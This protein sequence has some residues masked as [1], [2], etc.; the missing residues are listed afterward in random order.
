MKIEKL[1]SGSYRVRKMY[2]GKTYSVTFDDK[3]TQKAVL[4]ALSAE[5]DK[6]RTVR[7]GTTFA[8]A[9][10]EYADSK[11]NVLSPRT[12]KDY[13]EIPR[14]L[15]EWF[16][17]LPLSDISQ[18]EVN[19]VINELAVNRAP[20]TVRNYHGF[21]SAVLGTYRPDLALRTKLPQ[22]IK[23]EPYIPTQQD[24][25]VILKAAKG[26]KYEAAIWLACFGLRRSE[27]CALTPEDIEND[28]VHINKAIVLNDKKEWVLKANKT[29]DSSR[30]IVISME[31]AN[32]IREQG[33]VF[34]GNPG[35]ITQW[36][37]VTEDRL[38]IPRFSLHKFRHYFASQM[39]AMGVPE[40]DILKMGGWSSD[41]VMKTVYRHSMMDREEQAKREAAAKLQAT[42]FS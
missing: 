26:T 42:L 24:V 23:K 27:I 21:I 39:S 36:L 30:D 35:A 7:H 25:Q 34:Q 19:R 11:R 29:T 13:V 38:G 20:K 8:A 2:Q 15:P 14:R 3:P 9:A 37:W 22:K 33:Y 31:L 18:A 1:P 12:I 5:M 17:A 41:Y 40:A 4:Q 6:V 32:L 28:V 10:A 16:N